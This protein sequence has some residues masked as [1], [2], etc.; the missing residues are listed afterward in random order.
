M[1]RT[2]FEVWVGG[3]YARVYNVRAC[4]LACTV[5]VCVCRTVECAGR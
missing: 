4:S 1:A 3:V 2:A 5:I